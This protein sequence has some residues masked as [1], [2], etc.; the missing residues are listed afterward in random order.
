MEQATLRSMIGDGKH[1]TAA[2]D[3]IDEVAAIVVRVDAAQRQWLEENGLQMHY[4]GGLYPSG[5]TITI[6]ITLMNVTVE[7]LASAAD[8]AKRSLLEQLSF[9]VQIP[10]YVVDPGN[11]LV[12]ETTVAH[13][14]FAR[15]ELID[16]LVKTAGHLRHCFVVDWPDTLRRY[17]QERD[18][19]PG[20][21]VETIIA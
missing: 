17:H 3:W 7:I 8:D 10:L 16:L 15:R 14:H 2:L 21:I 11:E 13:R 6:Q 18:D 20:N 19:P 12:R 5:A 9:Q 1:T 4:F